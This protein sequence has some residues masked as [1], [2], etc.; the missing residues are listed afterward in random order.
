[1][2]KLKQFLTFEDD[3]TS[4]KTLFIFIVLAFIF[5]VGVRYYWAYIFAGNPLS[6]WN[7]E[8]MIN[9]NDG[10][11][12]A[13]GARDILNGG[14]TPND[15]SAIT[16][17]ISII[18]AHLASIL[19]IK[20]ETLILW[21]PAVFGS[22]IVIPV[23][24]I[25]KVLN[26]TKM[27]FIAALIASITWSYY[28]RTML[29]YYDTDLLVIVLPT[30]VMWAL[31]LS[32]IT[33]KNRYIALTALFILINQWY[34]GGSYS[35]LMAISGLLFIYA[36]VFERKNIFYYK[37]IL[38]I[39]IAVNFPTFLSKLS[40]IVILFTIFHLTKGKSDKFVIPLLVLVV[41]YIFYLGGF[42]GILQKIDQYVIRQAVAEDINLKF[43]SV[44]QTV[45]EAGSIPFDTFANRISGSIPAFLLATIGTVLLIIRYPVMIITLPMVGLGFL[46]YSSGLRFTVY[47]VPIMA[48]G[49]S[50]LIL[51][52]GSKTANLP[53]RIVFITIASSAILYPNLKHVID[54]KVPTVFNSHEVKVLD[55]LHKIASREDYVV[56][57]WDYGFPI[58]YYSDIKT[59]VDGG[60]HSGYQNFAPSFILSTD[61]QTSAAN[62]ARL[63]VEYLEQS[64]INNSTGYNIV[65]MMKDYG[66]KDPANFLLSLKNT[67]KL[68]KKS[69]DIYLY[70]PNRMLNIFPTVALFSNMNILTGERY[71]RKYFSNVQAI[72][73]SPTEI[74]F[75]DGAILDKRKGVLQI[76]GTPVG[77]KDFYSVEYNQQFEVVTQK[78]SVR[79]NGALNVVYMKNYNQ[80]LIVDD[81]MLHSNFIQLFVFENY[82]KNLFEPVIKNPYAK[83]YK[84]KI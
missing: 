60:K 15:L 44:V 56:T 55:D 53:A 75:S 13:E 46:A 30:F 51:L 6:M 2:E 35:L 77:V 52:I 71:P 69:R 50:Y 18:T 45:R 4:T 28:N 66:F 20:F 34:Y 65:N 79:P 49:I 36:L 21:M 54:Y 76:G 62:M 78:Q 61:S 84:L 38:F 81:S 43:F 80:F 26:Q 39:L 7:G 58:R 25:G 24:L 73:N 57:W 82:D 72:A 63:E 14:H 70:L 37:A 40:A 17:P 68:P 74:R 42:N 5:S 33:Q 47:A 8:L 9:T 22:L 3:K 16:Q 19:P 31:V 10:Y 41:G 29:G 67:V 12:W 27:G 1:M 48:L 83:V 59:L 23:I 11:A 64:F 32:L